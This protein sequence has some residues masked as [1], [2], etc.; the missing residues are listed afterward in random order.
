M[1]LAAVMTELG[2]IELQERPM[3]TPEHGQAIVKVHAVG[4]CGSDASYF[5]H[6]RIGD[7]V[8]EGPMVLGHEA[9]G[10]IVELGA[11]VEGL[12]VGDKVAIEPGSPCR[13]C[14]ECM[15]GRYHLCADLAF[16]ATPPYD[17]AL[18]QF[19]AI[20]HRQLYVMPPGMTYEQGALVEPLSVGIWACQRAGLEPGDRVLVTGAGPVGILAAEVASAFGALHVTVTDPTEYRRQIATEHGFAVE[21]SASPSEET[22]DVLLE[23]SGA[24]GVLAQGLNR[25]SAAGRAAMVGLPHENSSLP[26]SSLNARELTL[27]LVHRYQNT[28]PLG[29]ALISSGRVNVDDL[30]THSFSLGE[31]A[32]ALD[33]SKTDAKSMKAMIYPQRA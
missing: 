20:D 27:S 28:W 8:V 23:C 33:V 21:D 6:G 30:Q 16:L 1:N 24:P 3:P 17:G 7:W 25:L 18:V 11:G 13:Q 2:C 29:I 12:S 19:M 15:A 9:A 31:T 5:R 32:A 22:F 26:L 10:E 4:V 14:K